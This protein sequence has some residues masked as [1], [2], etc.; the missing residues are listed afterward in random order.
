MTHAMPVCLYIANRLV[1]TTQLEIKITRP[2][3]RKIPS[4]QVAW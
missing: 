4:I 2:N 1:T 3:L